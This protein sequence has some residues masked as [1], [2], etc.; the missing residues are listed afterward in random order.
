[1]SETVLAVEDAA[2]ALPEVVERVRVSGE[3]ALLTSAGTPVAR[4]V[5]LAASG[6]S[7]DDLIAFLR[8]WRTEHPEADEQFGE[9]LEQSRRAVR[10][11]HDPWE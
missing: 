7:K 10:S 8:R 9:A 6:T 11:P 4:I 2:R 3:P 1:M 5:P